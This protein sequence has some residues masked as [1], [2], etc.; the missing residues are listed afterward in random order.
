MVANLDALA[1]LLSDND[2]DTV[3]L[4]KEQLMSLAD[5]NPLALEEL[6]NSDDDVVAG[7]AREVLVE[8]QGQKAREDFQLLCHLG[9][10]AFDLEQA[11]WCLARA[12]NPGLCTYD[13]QVMLNE[14]GRQYLSGIS[15]C[16]NNSDRVQLLSFQIANDLGFGGNSESY[17]CE[18]N[19]LLSSVIET[20]RGI[21]ITLT[22]LYILI[23]ARAA[24]KI[25]GINLPGHFIAKLGDVYFDP[26]NGC[27][28]LCKCDVEQI[29]ERQGLK[30]KDKHLQ[31]ASPRQFL[32]RMLAN[33]LY[34]YDLDGELEKHGMVKGWMDALS[35]GASA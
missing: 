17:Y 11:A 24:V 14:W 21:P 23:G 6:T 27:R 34:V 26:F 2:P 18:Q 4:V 10:E 31:A 29:L 30:L 20:R 5:A 16:L 33:L 15:R 13:H 25:E 35:A 28:I 22:L 12:I 9:G 8:I 32:M 1:K 19:S 7:H 3:H